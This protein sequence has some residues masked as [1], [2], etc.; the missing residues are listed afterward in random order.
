MVCFY[1][2][3]T[4]DIIIITFIYGVLLKN[5]GM[6]LFWDVLKIIK[7]KQESCSNLHFPAIPFYLSASPPKHSSYLQPLVVKPPLPSQP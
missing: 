4:V 6:F 5:R 3:N 1:K 7:C 2:N